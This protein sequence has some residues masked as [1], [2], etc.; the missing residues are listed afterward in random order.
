MGGRRARR[1]ST[2]A[3]FPIRWRR[4]LSSDRLQR[5]QGL[6]GALVGIQ[7]LH[8]PMR[9]VGQG[10]SKLII[11]CGFR[12]ALG[13]GC[14]NRHLLA[15]ARGLRERTELY[16]C[17]RRCPSVDDATS[18]AN[19]EHC[20]TRRLA[21]KADLVAELL[22]D[23]MAHTAQLLIRGALDKPNEADWRARRDH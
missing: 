1:V 10:V 6:D 21:R 13:A 11:S 14:R 22:R 16:P 23:H 18:Q 17:N 9:Q 5:V 12:M 2:A 3:T 15:I 20:G 7:G 8:E 4:S 19:T